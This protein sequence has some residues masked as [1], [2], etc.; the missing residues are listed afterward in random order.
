[1]HK[2]S[3][4]SSPTQSFAVVFPG[5]GSQYVGM[6]EE[7]LAHAPEAQEI[8]TQ[9]SEQ[10][11]Y[12]LAEL[13]AKDS[14]QRLNQ[15][16]YAQPAL[17]AVEFA[18]WGVLSRHFQ[19]DGAAM[20]VCLA[21]H[22]L[23][24]Y[25]ALAVA[26]VLDCGEAIALVAERGRCMQA[27]VAED[28]GA[29]CAILGLESEAVAELCLS[30][31][32]AQEVVSVANDNAPGQVVIAGHRAAVEKVRSLA[33]DKGARRTVMLSVSV[34]SHCELMRPAVERFAMRLHETTFS[35][36]NIP[37]IQNVDAISN[38]D[39]EEIKPRLLEQL[40]APVCWTD[41]IQKMVDMGVSRIIECGPNKV[42]TGLGR[43]I[44]P[45][46]EHV[47]WQDALK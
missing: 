3:K 9:A 30:A 42:L 7:V 31:A 15:T 5:Q 13:I 41:C 2:H 16:E 20:P 35:P 18:M 12:D 32:K 14:K 37:V 47:S 40:C 45:E 26:G 22:S 8:F 38:S 36:A 29:M 17:L 25:A 4:H 24:E 11:G 34:P 23:G 1:M 19:N 21:G 27:A 33:S 46:L 44:A 10:L 28:A 39:P 6:A 43:R